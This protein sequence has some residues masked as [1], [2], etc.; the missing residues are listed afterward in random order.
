MKRTKTDPQKSQRLSH[1]E[2]SLTSWILAVDEL[3]RLLKL[4]VPSNPSEPIRPATRH[5]PAALR[6]IASLN[7]GRRQVAILREL[8]DQEIEKLQHKEN[9]PC[10]PTPNS[11]ATPTSH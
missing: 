5:D 8:L 11:E 1:L 6:D 9:P 2:R 10:K 3:T 7:A 4:P